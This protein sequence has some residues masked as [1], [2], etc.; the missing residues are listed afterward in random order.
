MKTADLD[1]NVKAAKAKAS[2]GSLT[3]KELAKRKTQAT[4]SIQGISSGTP[5][6]TF[7]GIMAKVSQIMGCQ[8]THKAGNEELKQYEWKEARSAAGEWNGKITIQFSTEEEVKQ[9]FYAIH[10]M[11]AEIEGTCYAIEIENPLLELDGTKTWQ[12]AA[13]NQSPGGPSSGYQ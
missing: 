4:I 3:K 11:G 8:L 7:Q 9:I 6:A 2:A 1:S 10:G 13:P 5:T 12:G